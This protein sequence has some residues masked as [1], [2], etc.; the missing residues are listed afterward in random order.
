VKAALNTTYRNGKVSA[1][2]AWRRVKLLP[3]L[4]YHRPLPLHG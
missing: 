2:D 1:D 3:G 4:K